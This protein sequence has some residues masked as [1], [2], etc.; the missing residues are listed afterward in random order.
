MNLDKINKMLKIEIENPEAGDVGIDAYICSPYRACR[1]EGVIANLKAAKD[2][3]RYALVQGY[4]PICSHLFFTQFLDDRKPEERALG[5]A[6]GKRCI[7]F[8]DVFFVFLNEG[9]VIS[10]GM[11]EEIEYAQSKGKA[12]KF[13]TE[14]E[15]KAA[16]KEAKPKAAP[17]KA[18]AK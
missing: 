6:L 10:E 14:A 12:I 3:C 7:D 4:S 13:I 8:A 15:V 5:L 18:A 11:Q 17:K 2:Y 1:A 9:R 16:L